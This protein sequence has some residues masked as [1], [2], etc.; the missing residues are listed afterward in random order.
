MQITFL[1]DVRKVGRL[2]L[3]RTS[4]FHFWW[5]LWK[6][7]KFTFVNLKATWNSVGKTLASRAEGLRFG[8]LEIRVTP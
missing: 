1:N 4:G 3:S 2:V 6:Y 5:Q 7:R 8:H